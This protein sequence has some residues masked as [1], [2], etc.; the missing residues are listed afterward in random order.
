MQSAITKNTL[1]VRYSPGYTNLC[2]SIG[3]LLT[4]HMTASL[5]NIS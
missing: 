1:L 3:L 4:D 5:C 2:T